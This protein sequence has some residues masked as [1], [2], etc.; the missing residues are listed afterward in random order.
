[1]AR[2]LLCLGA[3]LLGSADKADRYAEEWSAD[4]E[5]VP[6]KLTKLGYA[7]GVLAWSVPRLRRQ[8]RRERR[9]A[10]APVALTAPQEWEW[11]TDWKSQAQCKR[12]DPDA[13]LNRAK[14]TCRGC[15]VRTECLA[16]ALD[17]PIEYDFGIW[18]GKTERER[19]ALLRRRP[20]VTSWRELLEPA[21][22]AYL[23]ESLD[24]LVAR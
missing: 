9:Q 16:N 13:A 18:G 2:R 5:E 7:V 21:H 4:L 10:A 6:G 14:L 19:R 3:R 22:K 24:D 8:Y 23:R 1:M 17:N 20:D 11:V 15:P 12:T